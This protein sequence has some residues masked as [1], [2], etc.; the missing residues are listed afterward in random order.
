MGID[1]ITTPYTIL[2]LILF[3][4][5]INDKISSLLT[6]DVIKIQFSVELPVRVVYD[7]PDS[8]VCP[9]TTPHCLMIRIEVSMIIDSNT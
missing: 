8:P 7:G 9:N 4:F 3:I 2:Y 6:I 1:V 5:M